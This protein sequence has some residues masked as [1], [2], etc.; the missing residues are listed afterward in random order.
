MF[1][2]VVCLHFPFYPAW[3]YLVSTAILLLLVAFTLR[4]SPLSSRLSALFSFWIREF[5]ARF[6]ISTEVVYVQ[7]CLVVTWLVPRETGAFSEH[8]LCAQ[9]NHAPVY[10]VTSSDAAYVGCVVMCLGATCNLHIWQHDRELLRATVPTRGW[11]GYRNNSQHRQ[12]TPKK[13]IQCNSISYGI[14]TTDTEIIVR[15]GN[16]HRRR[17]FSAT[18]SLMV[19]VQRIPK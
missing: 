16:S 11:D 19:S 9:Y 13:K 10:N 1:P 5:I 7:R 8:V 15:T 6:W 2:T 17:K 14:C 3:G 18:L 12:L 4:C